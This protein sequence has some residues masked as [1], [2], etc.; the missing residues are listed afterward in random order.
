ML[1]ERLQLGLELR[2]QLALGE[3]AAVGGLLQRRQR[4][5][6]AQHALHV[7]ARVPALRT[8]HTYHVS[9]PALLHYLAVHTAVRSL[10]DSFGETNTTI[11]Q[12]IIKT[13]TNRPQNDK[14][15]C[16]KHL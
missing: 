5:L 7:P 10:L 12:I 15:N 9:L 6:Q 4:A 1:P 8:P 14:V 11:M 2:A 16:L 3:L 13:E